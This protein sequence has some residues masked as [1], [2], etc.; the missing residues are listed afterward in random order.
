M[1]L[2]SYTLGT[3]RQPS[4]YPRQTSGDIVGRPSLTDEAAEIHPTSDL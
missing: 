1:F 3:H 4:L 2:T